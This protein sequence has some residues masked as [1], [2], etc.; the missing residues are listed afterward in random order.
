[1]TYDEAMAAVADKRREIDAL[2]AQIRDLQSV[3][4]PQPIPDFELAGWDGPVRLSALFGD[5]RDLI[6]IHNMGRACPACTMWA[7]GFNG[8]YD[9]LASRAAFVVTSPGPVDVQKVFAQSRGWRFPMASVAGTGLAEALGFKNRWPEDADMGGWDPG[10][11][12]LRRDGEQIMRLSQA[13]FGEFDGFCVVYSLFS[14]LP[15]ADTGWRPKYSY[16]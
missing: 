3:V 1:V 4:E 7:D 8:V 9:H 16:A 11:S 6:M 15:G 10:V 12:I 14:L 13:D 5:K 2:N